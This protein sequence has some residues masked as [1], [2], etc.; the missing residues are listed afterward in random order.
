MSK[1]LIIYYDGDNY[2]HKVVVKNTA[3]PSHSWLLPH[4]WDLRENVDV[5]A[6]AQILGDISSVMVA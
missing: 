1:Y 3:V 2:T 6:V 4:A 5:I